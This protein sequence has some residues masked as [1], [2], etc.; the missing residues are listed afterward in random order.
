MKA[1]APPSVDRCARSVASERSEPAPTVSSPPFTP[2]S[3]PP[4]PADTPPLAE[5]RAASTASLR[6]KKVES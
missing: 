6:V 3:L 1:T 2:S 4:A 5:P